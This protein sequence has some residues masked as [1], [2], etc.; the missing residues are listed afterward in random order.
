VR[1][2]E[3]HPGL[4]HPGAGAGGGE[5]DAEVGHQ[6]AAVV[7]QDVLRLD[8]AVDDPLPV[9]VVKR[10]RHLAGDPHRI[11]DRQLLLPRQP[12]PQR[13][14]LH[15]RHHVEQEAVGLAAVV[16]RQ[17]VGVLEVGGGGDLGDEALGADHGGQFGAE[18]LDGD[19]APVLEVL[20]EV[21]GGHAAGAELPLDAVAVGEGGGEAGWSVAQAGS[22]GQGTP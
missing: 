4:R 7:Q 15:V 20:G 8:V 3:R 21:H 16:Q 14:P 2:A 11:G 1:R 12:V 18:D 5:R 13:F 17:D 9:G 10:A 19:L 22:P 6:R